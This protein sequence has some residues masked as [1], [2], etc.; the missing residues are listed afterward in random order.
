M[1]FVEGKDAKIIEGLDLMRSGGM[2]EVQGKKALTH[3]K[4][5]SLPNVTI[6]SFSRLLI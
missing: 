6:K 5:S 3:Y 1:Y 4:N 2:R